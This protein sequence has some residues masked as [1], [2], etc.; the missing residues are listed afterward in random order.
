MSNRKGDDTVKI[1]HHKDN[2]VS[3]RVSESELL[4]IATGLGTRASKWR[5]AYRTYGDERAD[6]I[7]QG[8]ERLSSVTEGAYTK[9]HAATHP[10][11]K[12]AT[13]G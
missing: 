6:N 8:Y 1:T 3:L 9:L 12:H 4:L 2:T 5:D 11:T 13:E 10:T 7:A